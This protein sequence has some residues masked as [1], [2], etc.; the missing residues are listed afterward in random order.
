MKKVYIA[1]LMEMEEINTVTI[2]AASTLNPDAPAPSVTVKD[3][4]WHSEFSTK[5]NGT[6][7]LNIWD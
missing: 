6:S 2:I 7:W 1:P 5:A 3:D 4:E